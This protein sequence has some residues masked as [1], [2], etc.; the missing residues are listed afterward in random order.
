[1]DINLDLIKKIGLTTSASFSLE[2]FE[3]INEDTFSWLCND[4]YEP[5]KDINF[6]CIVVLNEEMVELIMAGIYD[7]VIRL[8]SLSSYAYSEKT[9]NLPIE[10]LVSGF[11]ACF[12]LK[13]KVI[14][15][16]DRRSPVPLYYR[17]ELA[18]V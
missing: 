13:L 11:L 7:N 18:P 15:A 17:A 12:N 16:I 10:E 2:E 1:M 6:G 14:A 8:E 3:E 4:N 9:I 5:S